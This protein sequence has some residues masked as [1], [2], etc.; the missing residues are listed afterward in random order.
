MKE[1]T[2]IESLTLDHQDLEG[3]VTQIESANGSGAAQRSF[4]ELNDAVE[5]HFK[6]EETCVYTR[7]REAS[8]TIDDALE[9]TLKRVERDHADIRQVL[10]SMGSVEAQGP[11]WNEK[12]R[13]LKAKVT[14]YSTREGQDLFP[15]LPKIFDEKQMDTIRKEYVA[16]N[17]GPQV[18]AA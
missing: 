6:A 13:D 11:V 15:Q 12:V 14:S 16:F 9:E 5:T 17:R 8:M 4:K 18:R 2:L 3:L 7:C 10:W 1:P